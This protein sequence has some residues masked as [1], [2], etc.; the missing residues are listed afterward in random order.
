MHQIV[1]GWSKSGVTAVNEV[2]LSSQTLT[3]SLAFLIW[4]C[5][6]SVMAT[7]NR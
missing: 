5:R 1:A 7:F 2:I 4:A 6:P 3:K